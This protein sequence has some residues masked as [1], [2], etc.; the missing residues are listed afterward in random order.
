MFLPGMGSEVRHLAS[1]C[2]TCNKAAEGATRN[3]NAIV[4]QD[5][6]TLAGK[7]YL[8][9]LVTLGTRHIDGHIQ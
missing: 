4:A 9:T 2:V 5:L 7:S 8:T 6:F 1:Q 3:T